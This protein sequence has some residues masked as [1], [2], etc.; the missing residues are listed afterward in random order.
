[1]SHAQIVT[2]SSKGQLVLPKALRVAAGLHS[3]STL[4]LTL[5]ADGSITARPVRGKLDDFFHALDQEGV[6]V[7]RDV[8]QAILEVVEGLDRETRRR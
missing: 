8:D 6:Q 1:M 4:A 3:G 2:L 7:P 5:G